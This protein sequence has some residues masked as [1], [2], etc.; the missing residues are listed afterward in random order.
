M[1]VAGVGA[2]GAPGIIWCVKGCTW[3]RGVLQL[4]S[5][6]SS[7]AVGASP[8]PRQ[9]ETGNCLDLVEG[10]TNKML[11]LSNPWR[12]DEMSFDVFST[13]VHGGL[14]PERKVNDLNHFN[15]LS[16]PPGNFLF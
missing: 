5:A 9:S 4:V 7:V 1:G 14:V 12:N 11:W 15:G 8:I 2:G 10:D 16:R 3:C 6:S 13:N